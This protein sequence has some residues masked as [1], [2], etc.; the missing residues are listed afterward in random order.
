[1]NRNEN[2]LSHL[3]VKTCSTSTGCYIKGAS[4]ITVMGNY[5]NEHLS[6]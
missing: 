1:M 6:F 3:D 4:A 2:Q 5:L